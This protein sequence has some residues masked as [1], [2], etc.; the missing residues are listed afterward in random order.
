MLF[1]TQLHLLRRVGGR[2]TSLPLAQQILQ[3]LTIVNRNLSKEIVSE[4]P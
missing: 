1:G 2:E 4:Q 3:Q